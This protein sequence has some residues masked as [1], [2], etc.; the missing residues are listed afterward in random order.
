MKKI[1]GINITYNNF[2]LKNIKSLD[3]KML[4]AKNNK[5]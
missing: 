3:N 5:Y 1:S 2:Y 4:I